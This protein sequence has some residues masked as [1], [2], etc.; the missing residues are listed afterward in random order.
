MGWAGPQRDPLHGFNSVAWAGMHAL[1]VSL[2][3][4]GSP[5][6]GRWE[7]PGAPAVAPAGGPGAAEGSRSWRLADQDLRGG[8]L[9]FAVGPFHLADG[10]RV[11]LLCQGQQVLVLHPLGGLGQQFPVG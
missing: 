1:A 5:R 4:T 11:A 3:E 9:Q 10:L 2:I 6:T 8:F 7:D